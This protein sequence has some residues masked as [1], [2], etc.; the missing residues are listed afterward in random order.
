MNKRLATNKEIYEENFKIARK[1]FLLN[2]GLE[3]SACA[4]AFIGDTHPTT[5]EAMKEAK[6]ILSKNTSILSTL[7]HGNTRQVVTATLARSGDPE[8]AMDKIKKIHKAL[9]KKFFNS[10]YLVLAAVM[11]YRSCKPSEYD[12]VVRRTREIY[13]LIRKD[14]PLLT[15]RE[16]IAS[17]VIMALTDTDEGKL[18][19]YCEQTF[20]ALKKH[21][22]SK[23]KI[24]YM[25]CT[26]S[27]FDGDCEAK[28][29]KSKGSYE[30][31]KEEGIRYDADAFAVV[32]AFAMIVDDKDKV[33]V[34]KEIKKTSDE[35]K[36]IRGLGPLGAGKRIR[37]IIASALVLDAYAQDSKNVSS[38]A[39]SAII[40]AIITEQIMI[41]AAASSAAASSAAAAS[42]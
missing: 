20:Q 29:A 28:A 34:A 40:S 12:T 42:S 21:F 23:N 31:L 26:L 1:A 30:L 39:I 15:G 24:Q 18:A 35:L 36:N 10:D 11:I 17:C 4:S 7:G 3:A 9:D 16:D 38:V 8:D 25:A 14:H 19:Q 2:S 37:N 5:E 22:F 32:S 27:A 13:K 6:K 33:Q 41:A